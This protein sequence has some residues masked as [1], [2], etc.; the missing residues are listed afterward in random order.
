ML[1]ALSDLAAPCLY[2]AHIVTDTYLM[3]YI[4]DELIGRYAQQIGQ[5]KNAGQRE[6]LRLVLSYLKRFGGYMQCAGE[7]AHS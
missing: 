5:V 4:G 1:A 2:Q 7:L 6:P 3:K